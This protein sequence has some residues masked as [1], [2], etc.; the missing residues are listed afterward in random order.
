LSRLD[1]RKT[2]VDD[3]IGIVLGNQFVNVHGHYRDDF[4][5]NPKGALVTI[6]KLRLHHQHMF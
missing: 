1:H 4:R 5:K 3:G 2:Q 6:L